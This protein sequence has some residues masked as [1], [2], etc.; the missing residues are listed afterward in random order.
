MNGFNGKIH[1][2]RRIFS[3]SGCPNEIFCSSIYDIG[4]VSGMFARRSSL[5]PAI[6]LLLSSFLCFYTESALPAIVVS[7]LLLFT[8][9]ALQRENT[10]KDTKTAGFLTAIL[11]CVAVLYVG[12]FL[13]SRL[14]AGY[15]GDS[16]TVFHCTVTE[17]TEDLSG[18]LDLVVRLEGGVLAKVSMRGEMG[19]V[20]V[21]CAGDELVLYGY[22][23]EPDGAGNP[24]EFNYR[25]Y[26]KT[27]GILCIVVCDRYE[28]AHKA[29]FPYSVTGYW[30]RAFFELKRL[31]F[32]VATEYF[33]DNYKGLTAAV[34][35]GDKSLIS[36]EIEHDFEASCCSHLLAVSGTHFSGFTVCL[37]FMLN[38]F[39][40]DRKH[41]FAVQTVFC[42]FIG[43][44]TGWGDSVTRAAVMSL[45]AFAE[46]DWMSALSLSAAVL[47]ME[48]PFTPMSSGFQLSFCAVIAI[49]LYSGRIKQMI[50]PFCAFEK[51]TSSVSVAISACLGLLP[52]WSDISMRADPAH[53]A[54]QIAGSYVAGIICTCFIPSVLFCSLLP[55]LS[56]YVS[57]PL[58]LL[59]KVLMTLVN[60]G[61]RLSETGGAV[62]NPG[63]LFLVSTGIT[64]FLFMIPPCALRRVLLKP[65]AL[66]LAIVIG[67]EAVSI[68]RK[69][70]CRIVFAD[71][72]QGDCCLILTDDRSCI[73]DGGTYAEGSSS[74]N[75]LLDYY[76]VDSVDICL[77][78]HWD[79]DHAGGIIALYEKGRTGNICTSYVPSEGMRSKEV[80]EF[81]CSTDLSEDLR[82]SFLSEISAVKAGDRIDL[83]DT[84]Y[85]DVLYPSEASDGG[86]EDSLV[87]MLHVQ[88]DGTTILFTGDIGQDTE[89]KLIC[90]DADLD[91]DILKVAHHG[92]RYSTS[93]GFIERCSPEIAVISV[94]A[95]N[96]YGHP[97]D[98][99]LERLADQKCK[100]LRTDEEGAVILEY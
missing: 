73:I 65:A 25:R 38:M 36:D 88:D 80:E 90:S 68:L 49:K 34:C 95:R 70:L 87:I 2:F 99:T 26:L 33:D 71:V 78:S 76:G 64:I 21:P 67:A 52:F 28:I 4:N 10:D 100:C 27:R 75:D 5:L 13:D 74:V 16:D 69:P 91:C 92:S 24:G 61:S 60:A 18:G 20:D 7:A 44:V 6:L 32:E 62:I 35:L 14:N 81:F 19:S 57:Q 15:E 94:G 93:K 66:I 3:R 89:E 12:F 96:S 29:R 31:M 42:L 23:N 58:L 22:L 56:Q 63:K 83:S 97:S 98:E 50:E 82:A 30:H 84:V 37:P 40:V 41:A 54:I 45:C 1:N 85:L 79:S 77:M 46:R 48:D 39:G 72:G 17:S 59:L 86:N 47:V 53:M 8:F 51:I 55:F 9:F 11:L 43:S